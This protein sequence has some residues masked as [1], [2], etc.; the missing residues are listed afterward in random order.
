[1]NT[2]YVIIKSLQQASGSNAKSII[3]EANKD[4]NL[5]QEYLR[6][7]MDPAIS[8]YQKRAPQPSKVGSCELAAINIINIVFMLNERKVTGKA[9]VEWLKDF[10]EEFTQESQELISLMISRSVGAGVGDT[11]VLKAFPGLFFVPPYM[12]CDLPSEKSE[13][14]F[15]NLNSIMVQKKADGSFCYLVVN[16]DG[17]AQAFT[18]NGSMYPSW[19]VERLL[20]GCP[21]N[22]GVAFVGELLVE[23]HNDLLNRQTGN[24]IYN[25]ILKGAPEEDFSQYK[26]VME[27]WDM[28]PVKDFREGVCENPYDGR[29]TAMENIIEWSCENLVVIETKCVSDMKQAMVVCKNYMLNGFEGGVIKDP[30]SIWKDHT[31]PHNIKIKCTFE[32]DYRITGIYEGTGKAKGMLGGISVATSDDLLQSNCG[33]G[34]TDDMRKFLWLPEN[35][36]TGGITTLIA[37]DVISKRGSNMKSLFLPIFSDLRFDKIEADSLERVLRQL[38]SAKGL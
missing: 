11:M 32:A 12:R 5:L 13:K 1:M 21:R 34:F 27:C 29:F 18:R 36:P 23:D 8:Y 14:H 17:S 35:N 26:F 28:L 37:N 7:V 2:L 38:A 10:M 25:S 30:S 20:V 3:L 15:N 6:A 16:I 9:A 24:G 22:L 4:S 33:S 19:L 31:S